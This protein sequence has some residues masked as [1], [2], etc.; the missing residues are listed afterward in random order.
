MDQLITFAENNAALSMAWLA[1]VSLLAFITIKSKIS[2]VKEINT[3]QLTLLM[4]R[5][6]GLVVDIRNENDFK[7]GHILGSQHLT[8]EKINNNELQSLEK[9]KAKPIIV[10]CAAGMT[11]IPA[12]RKLYKAGF[13]QV[14]TLKGGFAGWQ[15]ANLP[16]AKK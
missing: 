15:S 7:K 3:Q 4:N 13:T 14:S 11:A 2:P 1:I 16:V 5:E 8:S 6:D 9:A 10:V 12:A